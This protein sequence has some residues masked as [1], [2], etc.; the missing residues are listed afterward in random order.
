MNKRLLVS[1]FAAGLSVGAFAEKQVLINGAVAEKS[2]VVEITFKGDD[3]ELKYSD[4]SSFLLDMETVEIDFM[5]GTSLAGVSSGIF[6]LNSVPE[7]E[8][9]LQGVRQGALIQIIATGGKLL[10]ME[11]AGAGDV[12]IPISF[13]RPGAYLLKAGSQVVKFIKK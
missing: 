12:V 3:L 10:Y 7:E 4:G 13:L 6:S 9:R 8:L 11:Q 5:G 1:V 2:D